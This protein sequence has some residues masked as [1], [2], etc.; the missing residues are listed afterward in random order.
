VIA[1]T[2]VGLPAAVAAPSPYSLSG[3]VLLGP[4]HTPATAG[5]VQV[6]LVNTN[7]V[8]AYDRSAATAADGSFAL[9]D[10]KI[11]DYRV[12]FHDTLGRYPD[13]VEHNLTHRS[14]PVLDIMLGGDGPIAGAVTAAD[15]GDGVRGDVRL[16]GTAADGNVQQYYAR[17]DSDGNYA[18]QLLPRSSGIDWAL[19]FFPFS[20]GLA[21]VTLGAQN[22][23]AMPILLSA[24][25]LATG[26][27]RNFSLPVSA[28]IS[29]SIGGDVPTLAFGSSR[30]R[31]FLE[32]L[33]P[34]SET[35]IA[36]ERGPYMW[37][38]PDGTYTT[39]RLG[40]GSY[41]VEARWDHGGAI[42][43][44]FSDTVDVAAGEMGAADLVFA[45]DPYARDHSGDG[46]AEILQLTPKGALR[47]YAEADRFGPLGS[48][49]TLMS[50]L[51]TAKSVVN[52][53]DFSGDGFSDVITR[54]S[55]GS[56]WLY[57][58]TGANGFSPKVR[59]ATGLAGVTAILAPGDV[60]GDGDGDL[61][62]RGSTGIL[63]LYR[64]DGAGHLAG[65]VKL[66]TGWDR[67]TALAAP[68]D[69]DLDG[70]P[71][72]I[73]RGS[74]GKLYLFR[75]TGAGFGARTQI[76]SGWNKYTAIASVGDVNGDLLPDLLTLEPNGW[77][78]VHNGDGHGH[79]QSDWKY[80]LTGGWERFRLAS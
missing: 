22:I 39:F 61:V 33:E 24:D 27:P 69:F 26:A 53:G 59:I 31:I 66:A 35:W 17:S 37:T 46:R 25:D 49:V 2:G 6:T 77:L 8:H 10:V 41:R 7:E 29:G 55:A 9:T 20:Q 42:Q 15:T 79:L 47:A 67:Y 14:G 18:F 72:L 43:R 68:G 44:R 63:Y 76:G 60:D 16:Y 80:G 62:I 38:K 30:I 78:F 51:S 75:G 40:P 70:H 71:D 36:A 74:S 56:L 64:G 21:P 5:E 50:G 48:P 58:G 1:L 32:Y 13:Y 57:K 28:W 45:R 11:G 34:E 73:A 65:R 54:D 4:D 52:A 19:E 3:R 12:T 23:D